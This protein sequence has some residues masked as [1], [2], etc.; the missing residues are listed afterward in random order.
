M[1]RKAALHTMARKRGWTRR[2][3]MLMTRTRMA[4]RRRYDA[5]VAYYVCFV[6]P[7]L[8]V[9]VLVLKDTPIGPTLRVCLYLVRSTLRF[10]SPLPPARSQSPNV[11]PKEKLYPYSNGW[12]TYRNITST[13]TLTCSRYSHR[14]IMY[15]RKLK[16]HCLHCSSSASLKSTLS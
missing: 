3:Y 4:M 16:P 13:S 14:L 10:V 11:F 9:L 6:E 1:G 5:S 15:S 12:R 8:V 7:S 2:H